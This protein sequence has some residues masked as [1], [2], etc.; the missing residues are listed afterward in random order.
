MRIALLSTSDTDLLSARASGAD[1]TWANPGRPGHTDMVEAI[2]GADLVVAR[3]LG[4][5][6]DLC[7]GFHRIRATGKPVVV[8]GGEQTPNAE[9]MEMSTVPV[10]VA[11]EAHRY[12]AEGGP[13]NLGQLHA[14]LSDTV[15]LTGEGF[16]PPAEL[17]TWGFAERP[18]GVEGHSV[19]TCCPRTSTTGSVVGVR[20]APAHGLGYE[21]ASLEATSLETAPPLRVGVLYY[22]AHEASGNTAFVHALAD[23]IDAA[24]GGQAVGV[25]IFAGSLRSAPDELYAALGTLDALVLTVLAAGGSVPASAGAGEAD[26]AWDV[27]RMA[28]LD[29]PVLQGLALTS[30][31]AEWAAYMEGFSKKDAAAELI[32]QFKVAL[33]KPHYDMYVAAWTRLKALDDLRPLHECREGLLQRLEAVAPAW[34]EAIRKRKPPHDR[35]ELPGDC[36]AAWRYRQWESRLSRIVKTDLD[37]LQ[38]QLTAVK[39]QLR[40]PAPAP[41]AENDGAS[42][43]APSTVA[44][45]VR[46]TDLHRSGAL[47]DEEFVA[48]KAKLLQ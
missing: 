34:A 23:A 43:P 48:A 18:D 35:G 41:E 37:G 45:L 30:S 22:R 5:P 29:I 26:E 36:K 42:A 46:L 13:R 40:R 47:N 15:L 31:R 3:I 8:L 21:R 24:G 4:S 44:E 25:P 33:K 17:P 38:N 1:Y 14:F 28:A 16:E 19:Q 9:L 27:E 10:G 2:E 12:L 6:H 20:G 32:K 7:T 11:A 39:D